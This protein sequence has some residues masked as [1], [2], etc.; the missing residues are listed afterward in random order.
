MLNIYTVNE[1]SKILRISYEQVRELVIS[2]ELHG[3]D[4]GNGQHRIWRI[5]EKSITEFIEK[6]G[7]K[8]PLR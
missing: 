6:G 8:E 4:V 3:V 5:P 1:V 7:R 2:D